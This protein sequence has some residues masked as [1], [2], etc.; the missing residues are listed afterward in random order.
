[1]SISWLARRDFRGGV[2]QLSV[3]RLQGCE[4][5]IF[6]AQAGDFRAQGRIGVR[7][8]HQTRRARHGER[9]GDPDL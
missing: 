3:L 7:L 9:T 8:Q 1:M 6:L 2:G 4:G 5:G